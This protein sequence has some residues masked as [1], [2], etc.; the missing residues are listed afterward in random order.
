MTEGIS[1]PVIEEEEL[2]DLMLISSWNQLTAQVGGQIVNYWNN[3]EYFK[4]SQTENNDESVL[5]L[6]SVSNF[7]DQTHSCNYDV[8][9]GNNN[10]HNL[11]SQTKFYTTPSSYSDCERVHKSP[12]WCNDYSLLMSYADDITPQGSIFLGH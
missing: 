11:K 5:F 12:H 4:E 8:S 2:P 6:V 7:S 9:D 3:L 10:A 1:I